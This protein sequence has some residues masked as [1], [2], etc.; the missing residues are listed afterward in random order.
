M[1]K[2]VLLALLFSLSATTFMSAQSKK[3]QKEIFAATYKTSKSVVETEHY[4]FVANVI[5]NSQER[6]ILN[7]DVNKI[8]IN[9]LSV[10]GQLHAFSKD[11]AVHSLKDNNSEISTTFNDE[12]QEISISIKTK[13]Y[14]IS[15]NVKPNGNAFLELTN[16]NNTK[17]LYTGK[18]VRL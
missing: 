2:L 1:K 12:D 7:G 17:L 6:E 13:A 11:R 16:T 9:K 5:R 15:I 14:T 4:Q 18:L 3:S 8:E 10:S